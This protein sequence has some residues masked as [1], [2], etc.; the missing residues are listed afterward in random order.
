MKRKEEV[1]TAL[2]LPESSEATEIHPEVRR[3]PLS[4]LVIDPEYQRPEAP[5]WV[6]YLV[7]NWRPRAAG[8]L[9]VSARP[10][11]KFAVMSGQHRVRAMER[12]GITHWDCEVFSGLSV[13]EEADIFHNSKQRGMHKL[14][15][16]RAALKAEDPEAVAIFE[17]VTAAGY[18]IA[19][20]A[21]NS[22]SGGISAVE[23]LATILRWGVLPEALKFLQK[24]WP[25]GITAEHDLVTQRTFLMA[26]GGLMRGYGQHPFFSYTEAVKRLGSTPPK[27]WLEKGEMGSA[28][29]STTTQW[30]GLLWQWIMRLN[31]SKQFKKLP[32]P[33]FGPAEMRAWKIKVE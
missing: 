20:E 17:A 8:M 23:S 27:I 6:N 32:L 29:L 12:L 22:K 3:L 30:H 7:D 1:A 19:F 18:T 16:F 33:T 26:A 31:K 5:R 2:K 14:D 15:E 13:K 10:N 25:A 9:R 11:G 24:T 28:T 4:S 21:K